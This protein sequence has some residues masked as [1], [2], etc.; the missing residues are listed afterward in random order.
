MNTDF[1]YLPIPDITLP[2]TTPKGDYGAVVMDPILHLL[3]H[4]GL[5][6]FGTPAPAQRTPPTFESFGIPLAFVLYETYLPRNRSDPSVLDVSFIHDRGYVYDEHRFLGILSRTH[7]VSNVSLL[8]PYG[9]RLNI[10]VE[11]QGHVNDGKKM[12][13]FKV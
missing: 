10:F 7:G 13:D 9:R 5:S 6:L 8:S 1:Q 2:P 4:R 3:T 11:N 12:V